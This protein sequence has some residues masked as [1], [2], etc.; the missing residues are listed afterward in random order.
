MSISITK[1]KK[2]LLIKRIGP[3]VVSNFFRKTLNYEHFWEKFSPH[4]IKKDFFFINLYFIWVSRRWG[5]GVRGGR[6]REGGR[7]WETQKFVVLI[8]FKLN[9]YL[10]T[11]SSYL[12]ILSLHFSSFLSR[13]VF[14]NVLNGTIRYVMVPRLYC[15]AKIT[16]TKFSFLYMQKSADEVKKKLI[17]SLPIQN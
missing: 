9:Y 11:M 16:R 3:L 5:E 15:R 13:Q 12:I 2:Y 7:R 6:G 14:N 10:I 1:K 8:T 4:F 17:L